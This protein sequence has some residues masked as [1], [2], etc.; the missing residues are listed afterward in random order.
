MSLPLLL[1]DAG[2]DLEEITEVT[3]I[4]ADE[5]SAAYE[6]E[7]F[8]APDTIVAYGTEEGDLAQDEQPL[9][10]VLPEQPGR[11]NVRMLARIEVSS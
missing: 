5:F 11:M 10:M 3:A 7:L 2:F 4:A 6:R 9:R 8:S 1:Q